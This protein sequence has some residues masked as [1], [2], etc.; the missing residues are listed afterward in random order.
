MSTDPMQIPSGIVSISEVEQFYSLLPKIQE[1]ESY[2]ENQQQEQYLS[3]IKEK[4]LRPYSLDISIR[5]SAI[6][7]PSEPT[8]AP[9]TVFNDQTNFVIDFI[10]SDYKLF[11]DTFLSNI[12][13]F[14]TKTCNDLETIETNEPKEA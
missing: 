3:E 8:Q 13:D 7:H 9:T 11:I 6:E 10:I 2:V 4:G 12:K 14:L 5:C 1:L